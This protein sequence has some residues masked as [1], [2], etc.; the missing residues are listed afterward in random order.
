MAVRLVTVESCEKVADGLYVYPGVPLEVLS[1][2]QELKGLMS[3]GP[4]ELRL[5]DGTR[6]QSRLVRFGVSVFKAGDGSFYVPGD[7]KGPRFTMMFTLSPELEPCDVPPG[8]EI[9]FVPS[10]PDGN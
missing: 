5:P 7:E 2:N 8:T 9:W 10:P 6:R 1:A 3:N 4:I